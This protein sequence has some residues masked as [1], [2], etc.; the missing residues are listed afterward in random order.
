MI[1]AFLLLKAFEPNRKTQVGS[2]TDSFNSI[3]FHLA[4]QIRGNHLFYGGGGG[5]G[6]KRLDRKLKLAE[7]PIRQKPQ[8]N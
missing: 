6:W 8:K 5:C 7:V 4:R 1:S 2:R 3:H